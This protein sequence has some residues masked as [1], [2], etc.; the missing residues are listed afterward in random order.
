M[1]RLMSIYCSIFGHGFT[2]IFWDQNGRRAVCARCGEN[3]Y[4]PLDS[5]AMRQIDQDERRT[6]RTEDAPEE[7]IISSRL[8]AKLDG[9]K[10]TV[11]AT[12][13]AIFVRLEGY[14]TAVEDE[15]WPIRIDWFHGYPTV[16]LWADINQE[17]PTHV[18][19]LENALEDP[20]THFEEVTCQPQS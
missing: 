13:D 1:L 15:G 19:T 5:R 8:H 3:I 16:Y 2:R 20:T 14:G 18:I 7:G 6:T 9:H 4:Q 10:V 12:G 17:D 11:E